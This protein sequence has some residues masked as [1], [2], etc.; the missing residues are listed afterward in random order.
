MDA[1]HLSPDDFRALAHRMVDHVADYLTRVRDLPVSPPG[2]APGDLARALPTLP[3]L[4][5]GGPHE[6]DSIFHDLDA[7]ILP[8]L[9]HWQSPRFFAYFP[10]NASAPA[11]LAEILSAG[12]NI[13]GMLWATSPAATE[14]ESVMLDWFARA[15]GLPD[16]FLN[17]SPSGGGVIQGTASEAAL[18]AL[19]AAR[20]RALRRAR[21]D[22]ARDADHAVLYASEQAHS[23]IVKAAMIVGLASS[24]TDLA[25]VRLIPTDHAQALRP[26]HLR[27]ALR[28]DR[29]A[30][31]I[32]AMIVATLGSTATLAFDPLAD[33]ARARADLAPDAWLHVDAAHA[34]AAFVC[35]EHRAA[36]AGVEHADSFCFNPHKWLLTNFDCDLFWTRDRRAL[37]E[38]LSITPEYL[39]NTASDSGEVTDYRDWQIPLGRRFRSLKLWFVLRH[40]GLEGLR[41]HIRAHVTLANTLADLIR[42]DARF[43]LPFEPRLNLVALRH[44]AGDDATRALLARVNATGRALLSHAVVPGLGYVIRIA[45]G[46]P[47]TNLEDIRELAGLLRAHAD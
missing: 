13:N 12:L 44:R 46:T 42:T 19:V 7:L 14:L 27:D 11:I 40:Y 36:L 15:L 4:L 22:P 5:P 31:L 34:G 16:A 39:R 33:L 43:E 24:P 8:A 1:P 6:W 45:V 38:S 10:C 47:S 9:V 29:E 37:I 41:A 23:S 18:V 30:G 21:L 25:R 17:S 3:P 20:A 28:R 35:P 2:L 26:D 32:P